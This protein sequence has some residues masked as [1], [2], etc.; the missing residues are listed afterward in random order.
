MIL[1]IF[2]TQVKK[3]WGES[4]HCFFNDMSKGVGEKEG[5]GGGKADI[6][7]SQNEGTQRGLLLSHASF[8]IMFSP[9][10]IKR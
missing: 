5:G 8:V 9:A 2:D 7:F 4:R 3:G 1:D 6:N 10:K